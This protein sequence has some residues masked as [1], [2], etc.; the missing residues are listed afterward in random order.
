MVVSERSEATRRQLC[1]AVEWLVAT[2][3]LA[4]ATFRKVADAAGQRNTAAVSYHFGSIEILLRAVVEMRLRETE[5]DRLRMITDSGRPIE[6]FDGFMAWRCLARPLLGLADERSPHAHIRFLSQMSAAGLLSDPFDERIERPETPSITAL[7]Q[8]LQ[9]SLTGLPP[10]L[11]RA[12][13]ALCGMMFWNAVAL[14]DEQA[15]GTDVPVGLD[16]LLA[17]VEGLIR[18]MLTTA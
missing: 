16:I 13:I 7:L 9:A 12:R 2:Q 14:H 11:G 6:A 17:D 15:L 8:R 10:Q 1:L 3:G 4:N 5:A 18:G